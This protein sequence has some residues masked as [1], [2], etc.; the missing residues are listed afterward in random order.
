MEK[1][2]LVVSVKWSIFYI[3]WNIVIDK[4]QPRNWNLLKDMDQRQHHIKTHFVHL[5]ALFVLY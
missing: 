2:G 3:S 5:A 4:I 1:K